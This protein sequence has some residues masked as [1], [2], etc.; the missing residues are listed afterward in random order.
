MCRQ[1]LMLPDDQLKLC[2]L[3]RSSPEEPLGEYFLK[4]VIYG[5]ACAPWQ[6]I[7]TLHKYPRQFLSWLKTLTG[8]TSATLLAETLFEVCC[9]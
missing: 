2:T 5:V 6:A 8:V 1:I 4:T 7:R 3:W 9:S